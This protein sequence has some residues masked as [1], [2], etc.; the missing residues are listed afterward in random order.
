WE[1]R[2]VSECNYKWSAIGSRMDE[3]QADNPLVQYGYAIAA[4]VSTTSIS[5]G[6][7]FSVHNM[8][9]Q[10]YILHQPG[11]K[12]YHHQRVVLLLL[13]SRA[14]HHSRRLLYGCHL[15]AYHHHHRRCY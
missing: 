11:Y 3:E 8:H 6:S 13:H 4:Y 2:H 15:F 14:H 10:L 1:A 12:R 9:D 5:A 7:L